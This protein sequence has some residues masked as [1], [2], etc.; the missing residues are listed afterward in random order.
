[1]ILCMSEVSD[2]LA[3]E[4]IVV[5]PSDWIDSPLLA[6]QYFSVELLGFGQI[7]CGDGVVERFIGF[8]LLHLMDM[9]WNI[10]F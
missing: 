3:A 6:L 5:Y 10:K 9:N 8:Y 2:D 1:M 7:I 4:E